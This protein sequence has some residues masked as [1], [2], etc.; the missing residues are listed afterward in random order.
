MEL[1]IVQTGGDRL[2]KVLELRR[3]EL[4][5]TTKQATA[6]I[7][8]TAL[9]S[10]RALTKVA[11]PSRNKYSIAASSLKVAFDPSN[12]AAFLVNA[13]GQKVN[14]HN[15]RHAV[16]WVEKP[17]SR[18]HGLKVFRCIDIV[19]AAEGKSYES[20]V[21]ARDAAAAKRYLKERT[22]R[23][24]KARKGLARLALNHCMRGLA[25]D[26]MGGGSGVADG[27]LSAIAAKNVDVR[28]EEKGYNSGEISIRVHD[29]LRY[30]SKAVKGGPNAVDQ[31]VSNALNRIIGMVS[32]KLKK[33]GRVE[34]SLAVKALSTAQTA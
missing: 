33:E 11:N 8:V 15:L 31:A 10:L 25:R 32:Q 21:V 9:K 1:S 20:H 27:A 13:A 2:A 30:A 4:G 26:S 29:R 14:T 3:K 6:A 18:R 19:S 34:D 12:N 5:E 22:A 17:T 23:R 7:V 16:R 24:V 28:L